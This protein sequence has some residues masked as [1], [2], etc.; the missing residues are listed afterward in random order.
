LAPRAPNERAPRGPARG[1][2]Q[3]S[4]SEPD[5]AITAPE[6]AE[7]PLVPDDAGIDPVV[8]ALLHAAMF[9]DLSEEPT[10]DA[11][12]ARPVLERIGLYVQRLSDD[13]VEELAG[14]LS[15]LAERGAR[16]GW[17]PAAIEFVRSFVE[18]CGF[19][20]ESD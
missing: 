8:L 16:E 17:P 7:L 11:N 13:D 12:A 9:L 2:K 15:R 14:S 1:L 20:L 3:A 5:A 19:T 10:L 18:N 6:S 4:P